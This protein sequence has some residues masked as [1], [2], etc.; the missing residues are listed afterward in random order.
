VRA[1]SE[2]SAGDAHPVGRGTPVDP[3]ADVD[4]RP[5]RL[6][7]VAT[8]R[9]RSVGAKLSQRELGWSV[10]YRKALNG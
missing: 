4:V 9:P 7:D 5:S 6:A 8:P 3:I 1:A 2:A 10:P